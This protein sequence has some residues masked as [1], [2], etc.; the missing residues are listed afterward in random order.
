G[1]G[2]GLSFGSRIMGAFGLIEAV[3]ALALVAAIDARAHG[4]RSAGMRLGHFILA[5]V[6][7]TGVAY[8][9]PSLGGALAV[10][11]PLNPLAAV[12]YFSHF[13]EK[14][15]RELFAGRLIRVPDMPRSYVP[16]LFALKLPPLLSL[17]GFGGAAG[18]LVAA[19]RPGIAANRRA[20]FLLLALAAVLP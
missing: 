14:P 12:E 16:T 9:R 5:L 17:L 18:A 6:P 1:I 4:M 3:A 2:F 20:I 15:W 8:C 11:P 19:F 13:L 7:P 10:L